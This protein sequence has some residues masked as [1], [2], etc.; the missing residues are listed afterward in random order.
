MSLQLANILDILWCVCR[1]KSRH[2]C[3]APAYRAWHSALAAS[4]AWSACVLRP[5]CRAT[6]GSDTCN[7]TLW[8]HKIIGGIV[9]EKQTLDV[10]DIGCLTNFGAWSSDRG[11]NLHLQ[12]RVSAHRRHA[13]TKKGRTRAVS[14]STVSAA[15]CAAPLGA[16]GSA[17]DAAAACAS[18][19]SAAVVAA[20]TADTSQGMKPA[21]QRCQM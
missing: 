3:S 11:H 7:H 5:S 21:Q 18:A 20:A 4:A 9:Q 12:H 2:R 6:A 17:A 14:A 13:G 19:C 16:I 10:S 8:N 15:V 1:R